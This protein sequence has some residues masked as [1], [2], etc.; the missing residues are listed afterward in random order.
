MCKYAQE[1]SVVCQHL[2]SNGRLLRNTT[3]IWRR[4]GKFV[5]AYYC[6]SSHSLVTSQVKFWEDLMR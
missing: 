1:M 4:G 5:R 3:P 6:F 2:L